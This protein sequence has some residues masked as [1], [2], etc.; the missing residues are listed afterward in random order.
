M[1]FTRVCGT[2]G[3]ELWISY[4]ESEAHYHNAHYQKRKRA[5]R[6]LGELLFECQNTSKVSE[7]PAL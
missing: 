7:K 2:F 4:R 1:T 5:A 3:C 6:I